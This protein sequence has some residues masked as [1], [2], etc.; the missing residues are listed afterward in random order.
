MQREGADEERGRLR[1]ELP[2]ELMMSGMNRVRTMAFS[3][4]PSKPCIAEAV[5]ISERNRAQSQPARFRI[6][7]RKPISM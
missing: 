2:P 7:V 4:S 1:A 3:S 5:S 6:I